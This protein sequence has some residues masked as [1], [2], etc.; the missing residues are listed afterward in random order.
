MCSILGCGLMLQVALVQEG[1][2]VSLLLPSD[3]P[4]HMTASSVATF[5]LWNELG[6]K[7]CL[8]DHLY[9]IV[10]LNLYISHLKLHFALMIVDLLL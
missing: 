4:D 5:E 9:H 10:E 3:V 6:V 2:D 7:I 8:Q 1:R